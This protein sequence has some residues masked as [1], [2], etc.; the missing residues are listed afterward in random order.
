MKPA[1]VF[2]EDPQEIQTPEKITA[3]SNSNFALSFFFLPKAQR[4]GITRFYALSRL[5]DDAVDDYPPDEG[6]KL[7]EFWKEEI[8]LCYEGTPTHPVTLAM[9]E[10][11]RR[12]QIPKKY[13]DL[14]VEGCEMDLVKNR[15][16]TFDE[17]YQYCYRVAGVIGL[18]CMKIFGMEGE[19]A[20]Q[21]AVELGLAL[22]LTNIL[23]DIVADAEMGRIYIAQEDLQRYRLTEKELTEGPL[24]PKLH[25]LLKLYSDRAQYYFDRAFTQMKKH[26]RKPLLAAWI[27]GRVYQELLQRIRGNNFNVYSGKI[28]VSKPRKLWIALQEKLKAF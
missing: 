1:Q 17:L 26:P 15:Y 24:G 18:T 27:M 23:R 3:K 7:L 12:F 14:L 11:I 21:S 13:L 28:S 10:T 22:Q 2:P 8:Q 16:G 5:I 20:E 6:K 25:I 19:S 4:E 9:Q